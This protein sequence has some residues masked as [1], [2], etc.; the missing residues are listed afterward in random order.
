VYI[1][2]GMCVFIRGGYLTTAPGPHVRRPA[3]SPDKRPHRL[4]LERV[5]LHFA[6]KCLIC[7]VRRARIPS[8]QTLRQSSSSWKLFGV[9]AGNGRTET[10]RITAGMQRNELDP[11]PSPCLGPR[12]LHGAAND[13]NYVCKTEN[14][15]TW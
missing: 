2:L 7:N 12:S 1:T 4:W 10:N 6:L 14:E 5:R 15:S 3:P 11:A 9:V 8:T 13:G